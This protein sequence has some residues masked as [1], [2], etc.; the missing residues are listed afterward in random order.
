MT[1]IRNF[2]PRLRAIIKQLQA[3]LTQL[4]HN[5]DLVRAIYWS[6]QSTDMGPWERAYAKAEHVRR[7]LCKMRTVYQTFGVVLIDQLAI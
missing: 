2:F 7:R 3:R 5:V 6:S 1:E 4:W